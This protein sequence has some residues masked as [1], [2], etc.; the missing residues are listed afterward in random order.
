M[1]YPRDT[2]LDACP[3]LI[4]RRSGVCMNAKDELPCDRFYM[5]PD[6]YREA[7]ACRLERLYVEWGGN[8]DDLL[9]EAN[10]SDEEVAE[11]YNAFRERMA[12]IEAEERSLNVLASKR[13]LYT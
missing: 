4:C 3:N 8:P 12:E 6:E 10:P 9:S 2:S 7:L 13:R 1:D 5:D 11:L